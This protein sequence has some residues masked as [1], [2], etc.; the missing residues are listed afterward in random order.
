MPWSWAVES[1]QSIHDLKGKTTKGNLPNGFLAVVET[2]RGGTAGATR[3]TYTGIPVRYRY[4]TGPPPPPTVSVPYVLPFD[5]RC[6]VVVL[7]A[8]FHSLSV[9]ILKTRLLLRDSNSPRWKRDK[10]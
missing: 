2:S 3:F 5:V 10:Q 4:L 6:V 1:T 9:T 8:S 7:G